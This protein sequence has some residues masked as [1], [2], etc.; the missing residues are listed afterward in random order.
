ME[1]LLQL[2]VA[3]QLSE[4]SICGGSSKWE[5]WLKEEKRFVS[6]E[7]ITGFLPL[8]GPQTKTRDGVGPCELLM[9]I[10][11][12]MKLENGENFSLG[13]LRPSCGSRLKTGETQS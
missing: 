11:I 6:S 2:G 1:K 13:L 4:N 7:E 12:R 5:T 8:E 9:R 3:L 10:R